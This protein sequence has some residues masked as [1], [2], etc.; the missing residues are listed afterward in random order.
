ML[1][2][3]L[4]G[5]DNTRPEPIGWWGANQSSQNLLSVGLCRSYDPSGV[6]FNKA[7]S[8]KVAGD[9]KP[10]VLIAS[11]PDDRALLALNNEHH[12]LRETA[13][14]NVQH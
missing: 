11:D 10:I 7:R 6:S 5:Y 3:S 1:E 2:A 14:V 8:L 12:V 4:I 9:W 13:P